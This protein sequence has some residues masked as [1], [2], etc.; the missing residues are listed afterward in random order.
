[1][2][3]KPRVHPARAQPLEPPAT[4]VP[5]AIERLLRVYLG[6]RQS[7]ESFRQFTARRTDE[8]LRGFVAGQEVAAVA[9]DVSPGPPPHGVDG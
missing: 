3:Q 7:G 9:R 2:A 6:Q 8:E 5:A 4:E 1:M